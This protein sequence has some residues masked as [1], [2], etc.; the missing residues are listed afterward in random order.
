M[1]DT[2]ALAVISLKVSNIRICQN[3]AYITHFVVDK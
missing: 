1:F 3:A 2:I